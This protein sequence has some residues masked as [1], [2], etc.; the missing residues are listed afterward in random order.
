LSEPRRNRDHGAANVSVDDFE[1][2][3]L[4]DGSLVDVPGQDQLRAGVD[5]PGEDV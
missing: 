2:M 1:L 5:E 3:A 4:A